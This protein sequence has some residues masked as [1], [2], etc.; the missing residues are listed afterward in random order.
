MTALPLTSLVTLLI[1]ALL[2]GIGIHVGKARARYGVKAPA[3]TGNEM[4]ERAYRIQL[5]TLE[6]VVPLLISLWLYAAL[7]G[8][9]GAAAMGAVWLVARI[10]YAVSYQADP[11]KRGPGFGIA[12][13]ATAGLWLGALWGVLRVWM[14]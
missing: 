5:N 9:K 6:N 11:A 7:I 14:H 8:D 10:W 3:T 13:F 1:A 2:V 12:F 4:F